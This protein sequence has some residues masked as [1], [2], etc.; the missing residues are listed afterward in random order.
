MVH[1]KQEKI[2]ANLEKQY[3]I[4]KQHFQKQF[5]DASKIN[6][7]KFIDCMLLSCHIRVSE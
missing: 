4:V 2:V 3:T 7:Q 6:L 5:H 1:E